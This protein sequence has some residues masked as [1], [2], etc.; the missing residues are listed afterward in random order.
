MGTEQG[1]TRLS[2]QTKSRPI[3]AP[4]MALQPDIHE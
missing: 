1:L 4:L 3:L 2:V